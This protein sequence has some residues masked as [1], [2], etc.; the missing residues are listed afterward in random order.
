M[1]WNG[2]RPTKYRLNGFDAGHCSDTT[3]RE[4]IGPVIRELAR[5]KESRIL[6][7]N[8]MPD[9]V[10]MLITISPNY[11]VSLVIGFIEVKVQVI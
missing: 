9:H 8:M 4:E 6:E 10:H 7:G 1:E 3:L 11:S 5:Q 2:N